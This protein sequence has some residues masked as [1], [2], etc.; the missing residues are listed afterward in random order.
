MNCA[1]EVA[2][3]QSAYLSR[4]LVKARLHFTRAHGAC[5]E[6]KALHRAAHGGLCRV[7]LRRGDV[8]E[9]MKQLMLF[10]LTPLFN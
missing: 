3:G 7:A 1:E 2:L 5:H 10:L 4:D 9:G 6:D 8:L